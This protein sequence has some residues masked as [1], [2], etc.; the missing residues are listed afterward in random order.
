MSTKESFFGNDGRLSVHIPAANVRW[1]DFLT[2]SRL[3][4][5]KQGGWDF[6]EHW[7]TRGL[8]PLSEACGYLETWTQNS[9]NAQYPKPR[10]GEFNFRRDMSARRVATA[11]KAIDKV[12]TCCEHALNG[13]LF[14]K[15]GIEDPPDN[16]P[17]GETRLLG[18]EIPLCAEANEQFKVDLI[19]L[20][21]CVT[22][23]ELKQA[24]NKS[25]SPLLALVE[26][27]CYALQLKR[28]E[29]Y[30]RC[31]MPT[32]TEGHFQN[33]RLIIAA[34]EGYWHHWLTEENQK[35]SVRGRMEKIMAAVNTATKGTKLVLG[36][37][38]TILP[39]HVAQ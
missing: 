8:G 23:I 11:N 4:N 33:V 22:L 24:G 35:K 16:S 9:V 2:Y 38:V 30:L 14:Q 15:Y 6:K 28:C 10:R 32:L 18:Y 26:L 27:I 25:D 7:E 37:F 29:Q 39:Q 21:T 31:E 17:F 1:I 3:L 5:S 34:P 19:G 20:D 12:A 36:E 13:R